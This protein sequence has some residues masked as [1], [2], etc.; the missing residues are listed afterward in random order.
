MLN[1][2]QLL[3][4]L[5]LTFLKT[6]IPALAT[7]NSPTIIKP[8]RLKIGD[9]IGLVSPAS[10]INKSDLKYIKFQLAQ[11]GLKVKNYATVLDE[12]GYLAGSDINRAN[13]INAMF[14]DDSI[15]AILATNGGWGS[16]RIL[17]LL[18]YNL[19][20]NN[21]KII[22][23]Y[24]DITALLLAIYSQTKLSTFHGL[25]GISIWNSF[26]VDYWQRLLF[27]GEKIL[28]KNPSRVRVE[29]IYPG[30]ARGKLIG[31]NLSVISALVGSHYLPNWNNTIL[32]IE[33]IGEDIYRI[34]RMLN[35]L[36]LAG[37][38]N[39]L[40]GF[41][42]GQCTRCTKGEGN[43]PSLSLWQVLLDQIQ[44]LAI[45]AWYGSMIGH[46]RNKFTLPI[47]IEVEIDA[48]KGTIQMLESAVI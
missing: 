17:E 42:F 7:S 1:R 14:A 23:G 45:P 43:E 11:F 6:Q 16:G 22:L 46:I 40:S 2:R 33:D 20:Q 26:S 10:S 48:E 3:Q 31:G 39:Q 15:Q 41:I 44:P 30:I 4:S 36:K 19:I 32:F 9:T 24:S 25:V 12:Y 13:D 27:Q 28:Y 21:P 18:D 29:T 8:Q 38:L 5:G 34:D 47:G 35:H 37:I